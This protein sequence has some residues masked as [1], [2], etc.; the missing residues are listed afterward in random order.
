MTQIEKEA[1]FALYWG[2]EVMIFEDEHQTFKV[3]V[4][5]TS[6]NNRQINKQYLQLKPL[7]SI[8][9][10]DAKLLGYADAKSFQEVI[11]L[12]GYVA[13]RLEADKLRELG[14][15]VGWRNYSTEQLIESGI[16]KI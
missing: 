6:I 7:E 16:A 11:K 8:T 1:F 5:A 12:G 3:I 15:L 4:Q 13:I 14:Y 9:D 10:E 2:Q